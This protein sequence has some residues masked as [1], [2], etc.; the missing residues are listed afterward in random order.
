MLEQYY[1]KLVRASYQINSYC[2]M[3]P[4]QFSFGIFGYCRSEMKMGLGCQY[5]KTSAASFFLSTPFIS[6]QHANPFHHAPVCS[7]PSFRL[8]FMLQ[9]TTLPLFVSLMLC[10]FGVDHFLHPQLSS[11]PF[12]MMLIYKMLPFNSIGN[13]VSLCYVGCFLLCNDD[14]FVF[15]LVPCSY[16]LDLPA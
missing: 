15:Q 1:K 10:L 8:C 11:A 12:V 16:N 2:F 13:S 4:C 14:I 7:A 3:L 5:F 9:C 6:V